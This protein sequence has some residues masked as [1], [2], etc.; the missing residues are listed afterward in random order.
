MTGCH[1]A[2]E[3]P[4]GLIGEIAHFIFD[5]AP[6]PVAEIAFAASVGLMAGLVGR[7]YNVSGTGLNQYLL[8]I[9]PTGRGK[10]AIASGISKLT[11]AV[12]KHCPG[13]SDFEGPGEIASAQARTKW[14]AR[15]PCIYSIVG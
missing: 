3:F 5:A 9:T 13:I 10:E 1:S 2:A 12:Q 7:A 8:V 4:P 15:S 14:L 6:R 11:K